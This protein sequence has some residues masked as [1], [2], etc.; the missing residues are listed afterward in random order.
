MLR[1]FSR[2]LLLALAAMFAVSAAAHAQLPER[3]NLPRG[4]DANDWEAYFEMGDREFQRDPRK[5]MAAFY[6]ASRLDP[7]RAEPLFARW[8]AYYGNDQG[9]WIA[10]LTEDREILA[11]PAVI[12]NDS[13]LLWAYRRNPF[14]HRGL[15]VGLYTMLGRQLRWDGAMR[16]FV[17]Y[18]EADFAEAAQ[19]FGSIVR[20][21]PGRNV[22]FRHW[23]ALSFVGAGQ[24]DS[25]TAEI[26]ELLRVL[27]A[28]DSERLAYYYESKAM[29]E[30]ALGM[31]HEAGNR[32]A[33]ARRA[34][35]RALEEDLSMYPARSGLGRLALR[36]RKSAEA[37]E[38]LSQAVEIAP[39]DALMHLEYGNALMA[40]NRRDDAIAQYQ[41]VIAMEPFFADP[42]LRLG[43]ALQNAGQ[44]EGAIAAYRAYLER[45]PRRQQADIRRTNERLAQLQAAAN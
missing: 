5:A 21:N 34:F 6:W 44:R 35:E 30:Y 15:E 42:Y 12:A 4:A 17:E 1:I 37:V 29:Y 20:G 25:A 10:Y 3:P 9:S 23:R 14:V 13:L 40:A 16:A 33:E 22:R 24:L 8:A 38:Q 11:R 19:R 32:P 2:A 39:E 36:E 43:I 27:R 26:T 31:L 18:G 45:A 41:Q 7:T 28:T